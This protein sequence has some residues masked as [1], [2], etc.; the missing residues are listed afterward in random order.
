MDSGDEEGGHI[1][2]L[3]EVVDGEAGGE[4]SRRS[5]G[6]G[7][8]I[9]EA[10]GAPSR[11]CK[12]LGDSEGWRGGGATAVGAAGVEADGTERGPHMHVRL[13]EHGARAV[14]PYTCTGAPSLRLILRLSLRL[15][16]SLSL[17]LRQSLSL[18]QSL[19]QSLR[20][21]RCARPGQPH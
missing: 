2:P 13:R 20:L 3:A 8:K 16:Q 21:S 19:S 14:L 18:I 17:S 5:G 4:G 9:R 7:G 11:A 15:S 12:T 1:S 10:E 6:P